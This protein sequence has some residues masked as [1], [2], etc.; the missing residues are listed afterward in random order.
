MEYDNWNLSF[1]IFNIL[2][3]I[4]NFEFIALVIETKPKLVILYK[5]NI[6]INTVI[7]VKNSLQSHSIL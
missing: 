3:K 5:N 7:L 2:Y 4:Q 1:V 6:S